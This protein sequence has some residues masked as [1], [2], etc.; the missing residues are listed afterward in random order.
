MKMKT[1]CLTIEEQS[2]IVGLHKT[3]VKGVEI[4]AKL[5]YPKTTVYTVLKRFE[6]RRT[7][8]GTRRPRK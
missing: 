2:R 4:A 1:C 6:H 8:E 5:G 3:G 7:L